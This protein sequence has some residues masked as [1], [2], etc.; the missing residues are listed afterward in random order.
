MSTFFYKT[1]AGG[2]NDVIG[3]FTKFL[4]CNHF[5][6]QSSST[7]YSIN[8][9]RISFGSA[10]FE[11][12]NLYIKPTFN[13]DHFSRI[14]SFDEWFELVNSNRHTDTT[15]STENILVD[16][17]RG[18]KNLYN[19]ALQ[20]L[21]NKG[22]GS[23]VSET[24]V[25]KYAD[26]IL[27]QQFRSGKILSCYSLGENGL[28][29]LST[30]FEP[31][32]FNVVLQLRRGD[33]AVLYRSDFQGSY[34]YD[35]F[36]DDVLCGVPIPISEDKSSHFISTATLNYILDKRIGFIGERYKNEIPL[37]T[38]FSYLNSESF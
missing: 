33:L 11:L 10:D 2:L 6:L 16:C 36:E 7:L 14:I 35:L 32:R 37:K 30:S 18:N 13:E 38:Y 31:E 28:I 17:T 4:I 29:D 5:L 34:I 20:G 27:H 8:A 24:D 26:K 3:Q 15:T 1:V 9:K 21:I 12:D 22:L 25:R 23:E 19:P